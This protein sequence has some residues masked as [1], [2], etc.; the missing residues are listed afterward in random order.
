L[1]GVAPGQ[2]RR[3]LVAL[4]AKLVVV[5]R[6]D[7]RPRGRIDDGPRA[8]EMITQ[9]VVPAEHRA[10]RV[11]AW[12][13]RGQGLAGGR[14][15]AIEERALRVRDLREALDEEFGYAR[16]DDTVGTRDGLEEP[17]GVVAVAGG[18]GGEAGG[19]RDVALGEVYWSDWSE[20]EGGSPGRAG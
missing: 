1:L 2:R 15:I 20:G 11:A 17:S 9:D 13:R 10:T 18:W 6:L 14:G 8:A 5:D 4:V 7:H 19:R 12:G 16:D 3:F